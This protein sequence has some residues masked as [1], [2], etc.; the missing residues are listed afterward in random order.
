[1]ARTPSR[2]HLREHFRTYFIA[3]ILVTGPIALT[4]YLAWSFVGAVDGA[5]TALLP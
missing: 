3:G 5:V 2:F 1:M 4:L